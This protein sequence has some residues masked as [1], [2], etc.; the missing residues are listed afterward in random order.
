MATRIPEA[1]LSSFSKEMFA[2]IPEQI[3]VGVPTS[4]P[5]GTSGGI[6]KRISNRMHEEIP[7]RNPEG[8]YPIVYPTFYCT[9]YPN[10][11]PY[12]LHSHPS[13]RLP[14]LSTLSSTQ[15]LLKP[16]TLPS[17]QPYPLIFPILCPTLYFNPSPYST[18]SSTQ[19]FTL[20]STLTP[21]PNLLTNRLPYPSPSTLTFTLPSTLLP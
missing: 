18:L 12:P 1:I 7:E 2:E 10:A 19:L 14:Q 16:P 4:I 21:Y 3:A 13:Y 17:T 15:P 6:L 5:K 9:L 20:A 8:I 11:S